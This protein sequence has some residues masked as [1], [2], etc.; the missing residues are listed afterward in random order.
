MKIKIILILSL[1]IVIAVEGMAYIAKPS[2]L[3]PTIKW[4]ITDDGT[5]RIYGTG[6]MPN[7]YRDTPK[8]WRQKKYFP[9]QIKRI[10]I[11]EGVTEIGENAFSPTKAGTLSNVPIS[12]PS[13]L[14]V[15]H[16]GGLS[17]TRLENP[18]LPESLT[19]ASFSGLSSISDG[20]LI[21]P[22]SIKSL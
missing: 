6:E 7:F 11:G 15:I 2:N 19:F 9:H 10:E 18:I 21:F 12:L 20:K 8:Y 1:L 14:S 17:G 3:T 16:Y 4:E 5:L 22:E 13:T